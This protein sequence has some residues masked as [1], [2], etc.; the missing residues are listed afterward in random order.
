M[1]LVDQATLEMFVSVVLDENEEYESNQVSLY[2]YRSPDST[3]NEIIKVQLKES[4]NNIQETE[5]NSTFVKGL[6][7]ENDVSVTIRKRL[8]G[9]GV[10]LL[11]KQSQIQ[12]TGDKDYADQGLEINFSPTKGDTQFAKVIMQKEM[13]YC[14]LY[15]KVQGLITTVKL[16]RVDPTE[17]KV[18]FKFQFEDEI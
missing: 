10:I 14:I 11:S 17:I 2:E 15:V 6:V 7:L 5:G 4:W 16:V 1:H 8:N 3:D 9:F 18:I 12:Q 13:S